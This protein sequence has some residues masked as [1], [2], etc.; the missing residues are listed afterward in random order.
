MI[1]NEIERLNA[2]ID[3]A[4]KKINT[5][6][7]YSSNKNCVLW[8]NLKK[9][10][11]KAIELSNTKCVDVLISEKY[12]NGR[13]IDQLIE[14]RCMAERVKIYKEILNSV[15]ESDSIILHYNNAIS[16]YKAKIEELG[17][18]PEIKKRR[19]I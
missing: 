16:K 1:S 2:E 12:K 9:D 6:S 15:E 13:H 3:L 17:K 11:D 18:T 4:K 5:A 14:A 19:I 10:F 7:I 8:K